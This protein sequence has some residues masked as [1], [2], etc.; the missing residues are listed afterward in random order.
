VT[1]SQE[2]LREEVARRI[3]AA[4][5]ELAARLDLL[6][7]D[8]LSA[9]QEEISRAAQDARVLAICVLRGFDLPTW[10]RATCAFAGRIDRAAAAD[11]R[12]DFTRTVFLAG[13]PDNLRDRFVFGHLADDGSAAWQDPAPL[14]NSA[15]LRRLLKLFD[16]SAELPTRPPAVVRVLADQDPQGR[17]PVRRELYVATAGVTIADCLVHLNHLL[18]EAVLDDVVGPGDQL[19]IRQAPWLPGLAGPFAA[20]RIANAPGRPDQL[21]AYAALT[22]EVPHV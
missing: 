10:V 17:V 7:P 5:P 1:I 4:R 13:N 18:V 14:E 8:G 2:L 9:A 16:G 22:E 20:L 19:I 11:W 3:S 6:T 21:R 15:T 12:R